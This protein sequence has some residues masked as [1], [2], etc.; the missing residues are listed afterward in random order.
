MLHRTPKPFYNKDGT[1]F[2]PDF[3]KFTRVTAA[4]QLKEGMVLI[5]KRLH[6][7]TILSLKDGYIWLGHKGG[8]RHI[9]RLT[10]KE[11]RIDDFILKF[12]NWIFLE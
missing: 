7:R 11:H 5:D 3:R 1:T 2:T 4:A 10:G 12:K 6:K 9:N 8:Y